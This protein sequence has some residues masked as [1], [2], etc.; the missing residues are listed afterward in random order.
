M[1]TTLIILAIVFSAFVIGDL[2]GIDREVHV[3][4]EIPEESNLNNPDG[5][6]TDDDIAS[7]TFTLSESDNAKEWAFEEEVLPDG[8]YIHLDSMELT[9]WDDGVRSVYPVL[10]I[11]EGFKNFNT[12]RGEFSALTKEVNHLSSYFDVWMPYSVQFYGDYFLHGYPTY[13][14][15]DRTPVPYGISGGCIRMDTEDMKEIFEFLEL[16]MPVVIT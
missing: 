3:D 12:P 16:G 14:D 9:L 5:W 2:M 8:V 6:I 11:R 1:K 10:A 15:E 7:I 13:N 4:E